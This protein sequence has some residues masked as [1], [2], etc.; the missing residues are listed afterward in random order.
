MFQY[1]GKNDV[2]VSVYLC[3]DQEVSI[4]FLIG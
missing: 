3:A 2:T 4:K 1:K